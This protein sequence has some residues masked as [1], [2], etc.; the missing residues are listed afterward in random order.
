M[1]KGSNPPPPK[2]LLFP[3]PPPPPPPP[4]RFLAEDIIIR[5][6]VT[7]VCATCN[8]KAEIQELESGRYFYWNCVA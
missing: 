2:N 6:E 3:P 4:K 1:K 7:N 5:K 8:S